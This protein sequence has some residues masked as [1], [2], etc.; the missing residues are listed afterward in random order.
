MSPFNLT[1]MRNSNVAYINRMRDQ[2]QLDPAYQRQGAVWSM[3]KKRLLIDSL[4]NGFDIPKIYLHEHSTPVSVGGKSIRYS[5][6]DGRQRLEAIWGFLDNEYALAD[7]FVLI[8][9]G[10][11]DAAGKS[12]SDL[13]ESEDWLAATLTS[14]NLD[15]CL[16]RTDD[17]ELIE[18][19][20]SRLNEAVPLNAAE[21]RNGRGGCMRPVVASLVKHPFFTKKLPFDNTRFRHYDLALKFLLWM[22]ARKP[23]DAKKRQLDTF[24]KDHMDKVTEVENL[25]LDVEK[26]LDGLKEVFEDKDRLL[27][28]LGM[29]S[30]Y[31][32]CFMA[33]PSGRAGYVTR[34]ALLDFNDARK[35][36]RYED[37]EALTKTQRQYL[38]FDGLAQRSTDGSALQFRLGVLN[39]F[40]DGVSKDSN[41]AAS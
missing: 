20:F 8:E 28:N 16:V 9:S 11:E 39:G 37:E 6:I 33:D 31:F 30:V 2:I 21:K 17:I 13:E 12:F 41:H 7:D 36:G 10:S 23:A 34:Q 26:V 5:L 1:A 18:E 35:I 27:A 24:W 14:M 40:L 4:L 22:D 25:R 38:E 29:V 19:M 32:L 3:E 15:I